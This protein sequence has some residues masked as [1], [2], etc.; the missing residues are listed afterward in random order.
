MQLNKSLRIFLF[1]AIA[2]FGFAFAGPKAEAGQSL[3]LAAVSPKQVPHLG[4]V[5][6]MSTSL[7]PKW[8]RV[9]NDI[10]SGGE[11]P[12]AGLEA[13]FAME[14]AA[15]PAFGAGTIGSGASWA[16]E[17]LFMQEGDDFVGPLSKRQLAERIHRRVN[18]LEYRE[19]SKG[20]YWQTPSETMALNQGDCEDFAI[21]ALYLALAS[22]IDPHDVGVA[23]GYDKLGRAHAVMLLDDGQELLS[24]DLNEKT[25][26]P[27]EDTRFSTKF[28][29]YLDR[30]LVLR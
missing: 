16:P 26:A 25:V 3:S 6:S 9:R 12:I 24:L 8:Q 28:V 11:T 7:H 27:V 22:G 13:L 4:T 5:V 17:R 14:P 19:D 21:M 20:D 30:L 1:A 15:G 29:A 10:L 18:Q 23:V 2:A